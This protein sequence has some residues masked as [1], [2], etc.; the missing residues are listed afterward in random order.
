MFEVY[1]K[2]KYFFFIFLDLFLI[3]LKEIF[4]FE[5][6]NEAICSRAGE[7]PTSKQEF[8]FEA[9]DEGIVPVLPSANGEVR[10]R[11][12]RAL[13]FFV[14][15]FEITPLEA[16]RYGVTFSNSTLSSFE[17][18][19]NPNLL[20]CFFSCCFY[21]LFLP[22]SAKNLQARAHNHLPFSARPG[23]LL[24]SPCKLRR[25]YTNRDQGKQSSDDKG[26]L[27]GSIAA[28]GMVV[29]K[30]RFRFGE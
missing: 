7:F 30:W 8:K 27:V 22:G 21:F 13:S 20:P 18:Q 29:L 9:R 25:I 26:L 3:Q 6:K 17:P 4:L 24:H 11:S 12:F 5:M 19:Q 23:L 28:V 14:L 1:L 10:D 2:K 15:L 16:Q